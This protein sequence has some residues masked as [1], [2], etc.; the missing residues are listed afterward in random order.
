MYM[1]PCK[2]GPT[3]RINSFILLW[4][5]KLFWGSSL[6]LLFDFG[7]TGFEVSYRRSIN[8]VLPIDSD[9]FQIQSL[10]MLLLAFLCSRGIVF[11]LATTGIVNCTF[12]CIGLH[13]SCSHCCASETAVLL[14]SRWGGIEQKCQVFFT[15]TVP[16]ISALFKHSYQS[17][18]R[19]AGYQADTSLYAIDSSSIKW[20]WL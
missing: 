19:A 12:L 4:C 5:S 7:S 17:R 8:L 11:M 20:V 2:R 18:V 13:L 10:A 3:T 16:L 9:R 14:P 15:P 6:L 1:Y